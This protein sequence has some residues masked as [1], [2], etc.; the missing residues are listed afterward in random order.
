MSFEHCYLER[1]KPFSIHTLS[2]T[3][4]LQILD[5]LNISVGSSIMKESVVTVVSFVVFLH[6]AEK[7]EEALVLVVPY[8]CHQRRSTVVIRVRRVAFV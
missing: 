8:S 6:V 1:I 7:V 3:Y 5:D 4:I 2:H